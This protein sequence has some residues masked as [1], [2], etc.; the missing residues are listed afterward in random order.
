MKTILFILIITLALPAAAQEK[1]VKFETGTLAQALAKARGKKTPDIVFVD[2][3]TT[4]CGPCKIVDQQIFPREE[5]GDFFNAR[6]VSIR[7]D[8]EAGE[9]PA[10]KEK[11]RVRGYPTFLFLDPDGNE[12]NRFM[13]VRDLA[14]FMEIVRLSLDPANS[15]AATRAV[16]E[17]TRTLDSAID[18]LK[19]LRR[20]SDES[21]VQEVAKLY[22]ELPERDRYSLPFWDFLSHALL[23]ANEDALLDAFL[24]DKLTADRYLSR[25]RVDDALYNALFDLARRYTGRALRSGNDSLALHRL[26]YL[27][28]VS[29]GKQEAPL[30][31]KA[32]RLFCDQRFSD[33]PPLFTAPAVAY[34][35]SP[36]RS[37]AESFFLNI[38][39]LPADAPRA[40]LNAKLQH[41]ARQNTYTQQ[42]L[43]DM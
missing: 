31:I 36:S 5:V 13:G 10:I 2:C 16:R 12:I 23:A 38:K 24:A 37:R 17:K 39:N 42:R 15:P 14:S 41:G 35:D 6:L 4:W 34:L 19:A 27:P 9:G 7:V 28:F 18:Y 40:Y 20:S 21:L 3:Y 26:S 43:D 1:G 11:Y 32:I 8:M 29:D 25:A 30:V 33:V 22:D